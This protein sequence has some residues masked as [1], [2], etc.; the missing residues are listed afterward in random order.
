VLHSYFDGEADATL[1]L[2]APEG[3]V[4]EDALPVVLRGWNGEYMKAGESRRV[5]FLQ[6]L[7]H[8]RLR[9]QPLAW[10]TAQIARSGETSSV[11][12]P[13]GEFEVTT[14]TVDVDGGR[15][16][17]YF[18]EAAPPYRVVRQTGPDGEELSLKGSTRLS[19]WKLNAP[20]GEKHLKEL[21][22]D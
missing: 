20:G 4:F 6:S 8:S 18:I 2:E 10:T 5:P 17:T 1:D 12:V 11:T 21:G 7:L 13:A 16:L 22:L 14:W 19:Y 15:R 9:H 3:G